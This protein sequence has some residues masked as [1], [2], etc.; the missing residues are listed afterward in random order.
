MHLV[1]SS[2][3]DL[4]SLVHS[5][6]SFWR[7]R[8]RSPQ[9]SSSSRS[10]RDR[11]SLPPVSI[12][13]PLCGLDPNLDANLESAF[14]LE[15]PL[16]RLEILLCVADSDDQ[17]VSVAERVMARHPSV[18]A[19]LLIGLSHLLLPHLQLELVFLV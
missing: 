6:H 3:P 8:L 5:S 10:T 1:F 14:V 4:T 15:Y 2:T 19:R 18:K 16:D 9:P 12:L 7:Y 11:Q 13:R 17:A